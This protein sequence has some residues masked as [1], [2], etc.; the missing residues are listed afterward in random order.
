MSKF[1]YEEN[2]LV[3]LDTQCQVCAFYNDGNFSEE[4]PQDE[5]LDI[6]NRKVVCKKMKKI[7]P[8]DLL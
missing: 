5:L 4:C 6:Q 8:V 3:I 1:I 2:E 7:N